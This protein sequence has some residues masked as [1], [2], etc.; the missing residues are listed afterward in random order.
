MECLFSSPAGRGQKFCLAATANHASFTTAATPKRRRYQGKSSRTH[1]HSGSGGAL[2][3]RFLWYNR[4]IRP[5]VHRL[6][7]SYMLRASTMNKSICQ[8]V[9]DHSHN[10][11]DRVDKLALD[12]R[13]DGPSVS[14]GSCHS[15][16]G[17]SSAGSACF[18]WVVYLVA[19]A[20]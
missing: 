10:R 2:A 8:P 13:R 11:A 5:A 15:K 17:A 4:S 6:N 3:T 9:L 19:G 7:S 18:I 16:S 20:V 12:S 1:T 14:S